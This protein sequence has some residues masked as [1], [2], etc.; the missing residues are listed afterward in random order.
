[1]RV[2]RFAAA[3]AAIGV[4]TTAGAGTAEAHS[5]A[6]RRAVR[7][8]VTHETAGTRD[9]RL[10]AGAD[11]AVANHLADP[12][13][14]KFSDE[15]VAL[16][17][18]DVV[19]VCGLV[20]AKNRSGGYNGRRPFYVKVDPTSGKPDSFNAE[21]ADADEITPDKFDEVCSGET[22]DK[23][24]QTQLREFI[25][26]Q[27]LDSVK[28]MAKDASRAAADARREFEATQ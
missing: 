6:D 7:T 15:F 16:S 22:S 8:E 21:I 18:Q 23:A 14:A 12:D 27:M 19:A 24:A 9:A 3:A 25:V 5:S 17:G 28:G 20:N 1:M 11:K 13:S 26:E 4:I 10:I 2:L